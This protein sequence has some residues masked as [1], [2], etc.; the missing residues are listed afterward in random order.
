MKD[1]A[2]RCQQDVPLHPHQQAH[3]HGQWTLADVAARVSFC[4]SHG[5]APSFSHVSNMYLKPTLSNPPYD[6]F[7]KCLSTR[8]TTLPTAELPA[9][10]THAACLSAQSELKLAGMTN[11]SPVHVQDMLHIGALK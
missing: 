3:V 1:S 7:L 9:A 4:Q 5:H 2:G 6:L 10:L 11:Y 8:L